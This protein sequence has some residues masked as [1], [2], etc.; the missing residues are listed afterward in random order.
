MSECVAELLASLSFKDGDSFL[1]EV[2]IKSAQSDRAGVLW[3]SLE[4]RGPAAAA[5][6]AAAAGSYTW[7]P[8][9]RHTTA[10]CEST[11][12][13]A[14][15]S[16][17]L[18]EN[19]GT[20]NLNL[21]SPHSGQQLVISCKTI[22][23]FKRLTQCFLLLVSCT[24][25]LVRILQTNRTSKICMFMCVHM[26][27]GWGGGSLF[28]VKPLTLW[29]GGLESLEGRVAVSGKFAVLD[30]VLGKYLLW[31]PRALLDWMRPAYFMED[32]LVHSQSW[33]KC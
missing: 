15:K 18:L 20:R 33:F 32:N 12:R 23:S 8:D 9:S 4:L 22:C 27:R 2:F 25:G 3:Y 13:R 30:R 14:K 5:A 26:Y 10:L 19:K 31:S 11:E 24:A 6:A 17:T 1:R 16:C 21:S 29:L 7:N 28:Y